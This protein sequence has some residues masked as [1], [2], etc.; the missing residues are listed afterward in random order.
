MSA[1]GGPVA[2]G[3]RL[4]GLPE[5]ALPRADEP[6]WPQLRIRRRVGPAA[7]DARAQIGDRSACLALGPGDWLELDRDALSAT[8]RTASPLDDD[9][10]IHPRL[11]PA[12]V[13][14]ARWLGREA[15]HAGGLLTPGGAWA[16]AG[17]NEAGKSTLLAAL[18]VDGTHVLADD[19]LVVDRAGT[20]YAGP[21]C[22][23]LRDAGLVAERARRRLRPVRD[24][25][26]QRMDL[27]A[28]AA[29]APLRGWI[30]L[31]WGTRVEAAPCPA[32]ARLGRLL[33]QRRWASEPIDLGFLLD[34]AALPAWTLRRPRGAAHLPATAA[35][36]RELA[37]DA[38]SVA[39]DAASRPVP[40][41]PAAA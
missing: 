9:T 40:S 25:T 11:A 1:G 39:A 17:G 32:S 28:V 15:F 38:P 36:L 24:A 23:D 5:R 8:Y 27:P 14:T 30:F 13:V 35:L 18:A 10:L 21:R 31:E 12:A 16:L 26:R 4:S 20:T 29:A 22:V 41:R 2:F 19:L 7:A 6:Q 37:G 3:L 34:L 33:D